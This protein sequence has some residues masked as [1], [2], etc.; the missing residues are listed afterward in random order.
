MFIKQDHKWYKFSNYTGDIEE[1]QKQK[2]S[3]KG[4]NIIGMDT[5]M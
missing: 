4:I 3:W 2:L 1:I 5:N